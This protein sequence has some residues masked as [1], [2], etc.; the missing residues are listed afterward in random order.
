MNIGLIPP[1][2]SPG[3]SININY[4]DTMPPESPSPHHFPKFISHRGNS[5]G[6]I[7][8]DEN[9]PALIQNILAQGLSVEVDVWGVE[10][11]S[12]T[13][14]YLGHDEPKYRVHESF[15]ISL[16]DSPRI[17]DSK[18]VNGMRESGVRN[19]AHIWSHCKNIEAHKVLQALDSA[20]GSFHHFIHDTDKY[21]ITSRNYV[22]TC[23]PEMRTKKIKMVLMD[24]TNTYI[25]NIS[26]IKE[27]EGIEAICSDDVSVLAKLVE[28]NTP[29]KT[30]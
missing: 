30:I 21:A 5:I 24:A 25:S 4:D 27:L 20:Y 19:E 3:V 16:Y 9:H 6:R 28:M 26:S 14:L 11:K 29:R 23:D 17:S 18:V 8:S 22:W 7:E 15:L 2:P 1:R 10:T 13:V 12:R